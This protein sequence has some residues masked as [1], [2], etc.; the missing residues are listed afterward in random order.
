MI[1]FSCFISL[2]YQNFCNGSWYSRVSWEIFQWIDQWGLVSQMIKM[3]KLFFALLICCVSHEVC[4]WLVLRKLKLFLSKNPG[5]S[6]TNIPKSSRLDLYFLMKTLTAL[7][8]QLLFW[9]IQTPPMKPSSNH[10]KSSFPALSAISMLNLYP[11]QVLSSKRSRI[12]NMR[13]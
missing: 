4:H 12:W 9:K 10:Q 5:N 11:E 1:I 8:P 6:F 3:S 7:Q 13:F 2:S